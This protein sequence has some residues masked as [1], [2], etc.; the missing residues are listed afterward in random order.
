MAEGVA[1]GPAHPGRMVVVGGW[2][3]R[4]LQRR[5][6]CPLIAEYALLFLWWGWVV[7]VSDRWELCPSGWLFSRVECV[8]IQVAPRADAVFRRCRVETRY[9]RGAYTN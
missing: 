2:M 5:F 1:P 7:G 6:S 8:V 9:I 3:L 4:F